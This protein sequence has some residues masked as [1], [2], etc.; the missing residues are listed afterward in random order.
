MIRLT[1]LDTSG[2][3]QSSLGLAPLMSRDVFAPALLLYADPRFGYDQ[4]A[5]NAAFAR[6]RRTIDS[7]ATLPLQEQYDTWRPTAGFTPEC[8]RV[9]NVTQSLL[10]VMRDADAE[11]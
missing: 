8:R 10:R 6:G 1:P 3:F 5:G 11:G 4:A 2:A 7:L 9:V